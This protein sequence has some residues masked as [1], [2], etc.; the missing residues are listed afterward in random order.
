MI[1]VCKVRSSVYAYIITKAAVFIYD[2]IADITTFADAHFWKALAYR[3]GHILDSF[4]IIRT[5]DIAAHDCCARSYPGTNTYYAVF[6]SRSVN[7]ATFSNNG[8]LQ[9]G[10]ADLRR[11]EHTCTGVNGPAVIKEIERWYFIC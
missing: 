6:N 3:V 7:D 5:H 2:R 10:S 4:I 9:S 11:R 1:R 8:F